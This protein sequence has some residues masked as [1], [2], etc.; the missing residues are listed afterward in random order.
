MNKNDLG[1][2]LILAF[3]AILGGSKGRFFA[4]NPNFTRLRARKMRKK[5]KNEKVPKSFLFAYMIGSIYQIW[6]LL[7]L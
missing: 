2:F 1:T 6:N 4:E 3:F 7:V 5:S